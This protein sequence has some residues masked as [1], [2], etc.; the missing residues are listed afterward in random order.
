MS[1]VVF[2]AEQLQVIEAPP[3]NLLVSAAAGSGKTAVMTERLLERLIRG[4]VSVDH[5]LILTFT[6]AASESMEKRIRKRLTEAMEEASQDGR[7]EV[8]D[9]LREQLLLLSR[10][11]ISTIHAFCLWLIQNFPHEVVDAAAEPLLEADF[12]T[13]DP[14]AAE[15]LRQEALAAVMDRAYTDAEEQP[16]E[17]ADVFL[18]LVDNYSSARSDQQLRKLV[19]NL[20]NYLRSLPDYAQVVSK[21]LTELEETCRNFSAS[22]HMRYLVQGLRLRLDRALAVVPEL[23]RRLE[24]PLLQFAGKTA[25]TTHEDFAALFQSLFQTCQAMDGV[26]ERWEAEPQKVAVW[27][28]IYSLARG[29]EWKKP[30]VMKTDSDAKQTFVELLVKSFSDLLYYVDA[31]GAN[32]LGKQCIYPAQRVWTA[33]AEE[34]E[35][36][37]LGTLPLIK[38]L[39]GLVLELDEEYAR[40]KGQRKRIDF[41]DYEHFA[42]AVLR[43][44]DG[45]DFCRSQFREVYTDEYQDTSSIQES[46][47]QAVCPDKLFM[48][49]DVK[50]SIYRFRNARPETFLQKSA[51]FKDAKG[52]RYFGLNRN[53]RSEAGILQAINEV[54]QRVMARDFSGIA[55]ADGHAMEAG[56][57]DSCTR[58]RVELWINLEAESANLAENVTET[59]AAARDCLPPGLR[60]TVGAYTA[61]SWLE[62][63]ADLRM[64]FQAGL[65]IQRLHIEEGVPYSDIA[66]MTRKNHRCDEIARVLDQMRIPQNRSRRANVKDNYILQLQLALLQTLDNASQDIPLTTLMLSEILLEPFSEAELALI[67]LYQRSRHVSGNFYEAV[68]LI[69]H[70]SEEALGA[71]TARFLDRLDKWRSRAAQLSVRALLEEIWYSADYPATLLRDE[72]EE[73]ALLLEEFAQKV[74]EIEANGRDSLFS[75]VRFFEESLAMDRSEANAND[76][77]GEG[78]QVLTFHKSKGLEFPYVFLMD[79][80]KGLSDLDKK[81]KIMMS[82]DMGIGFDVASPDGSYTYPSLLRRAME[83]EKQ[84]RFL[85][86]EICLLYVA[87]SRAETKLYLCGSVKTKEGEPALPV[88]TVALLEQAASAGTLTLPAHILQEV[89]S[90]QDLLLLALCGHPDPGVQTFLSAIG[91]TAAGHAPLTPQSN[92]A[93]YAGGEDLAWTLRRLDDLADYAV[94]LERFTSQANRQPETDASVID[95]QG[96]MT[97][98]GEI[99]MPLAAFYEFATDHYPTLPKQTVSEIKRRSQLSENLDEENTDDVNLALLSPEDFADVEAAK[100]LKAAERGIA[101][102]TVLRFLDLE[103]LRVADS[104]EAERSL[105][106]QLEE[107][108]RY[109]FISEAEAQAIEPFSKQLITYAR[110]AVA[111][112]ILAAQA[113]GRRDTA[114]P[115][116]YH[117]LPFTFR[118]HDRHHAEALVQGVIDLWYWTESGPVLV[119]FKSDYLP[120]QEDEAQALL[121][122]RYEIQL[123]IYAMALETALGERLAR[124]DIWSIR[125]A[126]AF[127]FSRSLLGLQ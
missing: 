115:S 109:H 49:G 46:I 43:R 2:T 121:L 27:D 127:S 78:V 31:S 96:T 93:A 22:P 111:G 116:V 23:C 45:G 73:A 8:A 6:N 117:E 76:F 51:D 37:H 75:V 54:F 55:Y 44:P 21:K 14:E 36:A 62:G 95:L 72:G 86:E 97:Q 118:Y 38:R 9:R 107:L 60:Q 40:R 11:H 81:D 103:P 68:R 100:G 63:N 59:E 32:P 20:H 35:E 17:Q 106:G 65:E 64:A 77:D 112:E 120:E 102:H 33:P 67:R 42:L 88:K 70:G 114:K 16:G 47:L 90:Y 98:P 12:S 82:E 15:Q 99:T 89:S 79:L 25:Q 18:S 119:D 5:V 30:R 61:Q 29:M 39:F 58:G 105:A 122:Q 91:A 56:R 124:I 123:R 66:V 4:E 34:I 85:T 84:Q 26:L 113:V 1:K 13:L 24:D 83:S 50:Q 101:L 126:R 10:A 110:S 28:E 48:V 104:E 80:H 87:M 74:R 94:A 71:K 57:A 19:L 108:Q 69:A 7:T 3:G 92:S 41:A 53:F 52:G 125:L